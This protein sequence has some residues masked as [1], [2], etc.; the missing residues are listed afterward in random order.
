MNN[1]E[2]GVN[3][4]SG[5]EQLP[6]SAIQH[7][8]DNISLTSSEIGQ[9]WNTYMAQSMSKCMV[10]YLVAKCTDPDMRSVLQLILDVS[11]R[12]VNSIT[13]IFNKE[14]FPIP[15]GFTDE[16]FDIN[17]KSLF[18]DTYM[19]LYSKF[20][21]KYGL[22]NFSFAI[23]SI[24][25]PDIFA[26]YK[27][28]ILDF[29]EITERINI[30]LLSKGLLE[31][32]PYIPIPDRMEYVYPETNFFKGI[33]G[34][35]RPLNALEIGHIFI[36]ANTRQY[37]D[38]MYMGF[39]QVAKSKKLK[40]YFS[41]G[42]Q[43]ADK[44]T[45]VL[46]SFLEDEDLPKPVNFDHLVTD[47]TES[48]YSDKLLLFHSTIFMSLSIQA[49]GLALGNCARPDVA[50]TFARL[51]AELGIYVKDGLDLLIEHGWLERIPEAANRKELRTTNN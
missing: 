51:T 11:T 8:I 18:S 40:D 48:P 20:M 17:A 43:I 19:V 28:C 5:A 10:S 30:V 2:Q 22:I 36:N 32:T 21:T 29:T 27:G 46:G 6:Y 44:Q 13:E 35:K 49:Y 50:A 14:N 16:D 23:A 9:L 45:G 39:G 33:L 3:V 12:H 1:I 7:N 4:N 37:E 24:F 26:F 38:A 15:H 41:R 25:R 42:K 47:S 31:K 34:E